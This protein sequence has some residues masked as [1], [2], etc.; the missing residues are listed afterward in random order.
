MPFP[1]RPVLPLCPP[2][3]RVPKPWLR[4]P[5]AAAGLVFPVS[6]VPAEP[7]PTGLICHK[8]KPAS[9]STRGLRQ[10]EGAVSLLRQVLE[11]TF[12]FPHTHRLRCCPCENLDPSEVP[13]ETG[14]WRVRTVVRSREWQRSLRR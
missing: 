5:A 10:N 3:R 2:L 9:T 12:R 7:A 6:P 1:G 11:R 13:R 8:C 4:D 14:R